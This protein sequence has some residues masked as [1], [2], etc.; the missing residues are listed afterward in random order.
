MFLKYGYR[1]SDSASLMVET[2]TRKAS[3]GYCP[4][5]VSSD[6]RIASVPS[7][8][9]LLTSETSALVGVGEMTMLR[10]IWVAITTPFPA[11]LALST[12]RRC[13]RGTRSIGISTPRSPRATITESTSGRIESRLSMPSPRSSLAIT[14]ALLPAALRYRRAYRISSPVRTK[15]TATQSTCCST[16]NSRSSLSLLVKTGWSIGIPGRLTPLKDETTPELR[17]RQ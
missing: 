14:S 1:S 11:A 4:I 16:P 9:A 17:T 10:S 3:T 12:M 15:D 2:A 6:S 8:T 13:I 5:A 7:R